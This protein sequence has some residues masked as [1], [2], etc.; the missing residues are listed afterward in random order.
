MP[1][2]TGHPVARMITWLLRLGLA[3][4]FVYVGVIKAHDPLAFLSNVQAYH[5]LPAGLDV[6]VAFYL[7]WLEIFGGVAL[8]TPWL[9]RPSLAILMGLMVAFTIALASAALRGIDLSCGCFGGGGP[10]ASGTFYAGLIGRDLAILIA[11]GAV[12]WLMRRPCGEPEL[13]GEAAKA[14]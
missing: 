11:L 9:A 8:L 6:A 1:L 2:S 3:G 12:L 10:A 7:P 14:S 13:T 4:L 5:L